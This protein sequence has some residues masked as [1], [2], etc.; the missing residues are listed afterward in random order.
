ME[1]YSIQY[2]LSMHKGKCFHYRAA[3]KGILEIETTRFLQCDGG[4][5][6]ES[7]DKMVGADRAQEG[8]TKYSKGSKGT[9]HRR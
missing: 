4:R 1:H 8:T 5:V 7:C 9:A 6:N 2:A 3:Q